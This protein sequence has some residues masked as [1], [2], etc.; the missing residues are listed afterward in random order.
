MKKRIISAALA[1]LLAVS[2]L[3]T[4]AFGAIVAD[5]EIEATSVTALPTLTV[6]MPKTMGFIINPYLLTVDN[7]GKAVE[8]GGQQLGVI[9]D[10]LFNTGDVSATAWEITNKSGIKIDVSMYAVA[11]NENSKETQ[12]FNGATAGDNDISNVAKDAKKK[13]IALDL[14]GKGGTTA[15]ATAIT[16]VPTA[17]TAWSGT[18][19]TGVIKFAQVDNNGKVELTLGGSASKGTEATVDWNDADAV[20]IT[21]GFKFDF[22]ANTPASSG[23]GG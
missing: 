17:P 8:T 3:S 23:N 18:G 11:K 19:S 13:Y 7:K 1:S 16:L 9:A 5:N 2:A 20:S 21:Y 15:T 6:T 14:K 12:V 22:V 10:Y 4:T